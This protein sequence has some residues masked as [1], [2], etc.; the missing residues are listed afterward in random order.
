M[1]ESSKRLKLN[2]GLEIPIM[3][4]G[5][6]RLRNL[7]DAN[8]SLKG[9]DRMKDVE[10]VVYSSIKHGTRLIDTA[11]K[12]ENE[13]EVGKGIKKAIDE[14]IV[15]RED[16]FVITKMWPD[17]KEDPEKALKQSLERFS[18]HKKIDIEKSKLS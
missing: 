8:K 1:A 2:N 9:D 14:G 12:Y 17:E 10:E 3:G 15:K 4:L 6:T 13:V 7:D 18:L 11:S 16:L 5:T